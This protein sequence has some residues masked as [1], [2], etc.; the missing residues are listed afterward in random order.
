MAGIKIFLI[1]AVLGSVAGWFIY[2][3]LK[4][5]T[6]GEFW[7]A[8][9]TGIIGAYIGHYVFPIVFNPIKKLLGEVDIIPPILGAFFLVWILSK[10]SPGTH[11]SKIR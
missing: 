2:S 5:H 4:K 11:K 1:T 10:V 8:I 9:I 3:V 7:G 6:I